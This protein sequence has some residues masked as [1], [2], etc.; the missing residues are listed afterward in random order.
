MLIFSCPSPGKAVYYDWQKNY[1]ILS[2]LS[3]TKYPGQMAEMSGHCTSPSL[4]MGQGCRC[5]QGFLVRTAGKPESLT[6][7]R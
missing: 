4:G 7:L 3:I 6:V 2:K 5:V 1:S